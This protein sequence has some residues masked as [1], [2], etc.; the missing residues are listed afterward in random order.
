[1]AIKLTKEETRKKLLD[2]AVLITD[3]LDENDIPYILVYGTL[4][5][6]VRH[7]GFIPWDDDFDIAIPARYQYKLNK[8]FTSLS[9]CNFYSQKNHNYYD[10]VMRVS[11]QKTKVD[12]KETEWELYNHTMI[13]NDLGLC[14]D[15]Y[16][17]YIRPQNRLA[18][19]LHSF[20]T[21]SSAYLH[22][23][24]FVLKSKFIKSIAC[25][26]ERLRAVNFQGSYYTNA[27]EIYYGKQLFDDLKTCNFDGF[28]FKIPNNPEDFLV[29]RYG[30]WEKIP[31]KEEIQ[32]AVHYEDVYWR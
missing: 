21:K 10:W 17:F 3:L 27:G 25:N 6:A 7:K 24:S 31:T 20:F 22:K 28:N 15:I 5:G 32:Q 9:G 4:L 14:I 19:L 1:M 12:A 11:D 18:R 16:P 23:L 2:M 30:D 13:N 29:K 8:I 26:L